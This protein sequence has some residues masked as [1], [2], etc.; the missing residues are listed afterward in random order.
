MIIVTV[1]VMVMVMFVA[2]AVIIMVIMIIV[3]ILI[4]LKTIMIIMVKFMFRDLAGWK[5]WSSWGSCSRTCDGGRQTRRR[6]CT[7][8]KPN[9]CEGTKRQHRKCN[10]F[11]CK[12]R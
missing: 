12:G 11:R 5:P 7:R 4:F 10:T 9:T 6:R 1:M 8:I 3:I 2:V